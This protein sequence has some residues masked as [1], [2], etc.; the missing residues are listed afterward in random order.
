MQSQNLQTKSENLTQ[1]HLN[2]QK[3][4]NEESNEQEL[5][6]MADFYDD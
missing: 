1:D 2:T 4:E 6:N 5:E 3:D